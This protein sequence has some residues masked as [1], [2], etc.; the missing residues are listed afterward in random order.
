MNNQIT[1]NPIQQKMNPLF[2][3]KNP[4]VSN[5]NT[6]NNYGNNNIVKLKNEND[7]MNKDSFF[8]R[9]N[10]NKNMKISNYTDNDMKFLIKGKIKD[11]NTN[12]NLNGRINTEGIGIK[13]GFHYNNIDNGNTYMNKDYNN[14]QL[15]NFNDNKAI[16]PSIF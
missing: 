13:G 4:I 11:M 16:L 14:S 1:K 7:E 15:N 6:F 8:G 2:N 5:I 12:G 3:N 9:N 10:N